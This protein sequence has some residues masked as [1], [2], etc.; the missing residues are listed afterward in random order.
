[1]FKEYGELSSL[2]YEA[3][4]PVGRSINGDIEYY[5][6]ELEGIT[7]P[8]LEAGVGT[9]R[10]LIPLAKSGLKIDG[11]DISAEMLARCRLNMENH[12]ASAKLYEQDLTRMSLPH[13]YG[14]IMMPTGSFCLLPKE[15]AGDVLAS[16]Y[17]HLAVG[18][19]IVIDIELPADF[20]K[21]ETN[22]YSTHLSGGTGIL[23]TSYS[24]DIDWLAQR[25]RYIHKY[26]LLRNGEVQETEVSNFTLHWY[27]VQEFEMLLQKVG[28]SDI[29][30]E[31][32]YGV[33][34]Q[35]QLITF[36]GTKKTAV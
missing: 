30:Y 22:S 14:A 7:N 24:E 35:S 21:G 5:I 9:G 29:R 13:K 27:G 16:F 23:F 17:E 19:K 34:E 11:V 15:Q 33:D 25:V 3:T 36:T 26:E 18:G 32:G 28:Y 12:S 2:L 10:M 31:V 6:K 20:R 1:M 4:K 8:I